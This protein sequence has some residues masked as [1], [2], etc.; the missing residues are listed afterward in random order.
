M[1]QR[2]WVWGSIGL[3]LGASAPISSAQ[4]QGREVEEEDEVADLLGDAESIEELAL[5]DLLT[6]ETDVAA[7]VSSEVREAPS[8]ITVI[9]HEEIVRMGARDLIDV[10]RTVPGLYFG[11]D[12]EGAVGLGF[13]G[14]WGHE[15]KILLIIDGQEVNE[16]LYSTTQFGNHYPVDHIERIEVVRGPGSVNYGGY[17]ELAV[18]RITTRGAR[19]L[20]GFA[21]SLT[22]GQLWSTSLD[23]YGRRNLS[24]QYGAES[25][26]IEGLAVSLAGFV[27][28]GRRGRAQYTDFYGTSRPIYLNRHDPLFV[29]LGVNYRQLSTRVIVDYYR[30]PM[31]DAFDAVLVERPNMSFL[32]VLAGTKLTIPATDDLTITPG[33]NF[34]Y[35]APWQMTELEGGGVDYV[36]IG[37]FY[38]REVMRFRGQVVA[39][40]EAHEYVTATLGLQAYA[41]Q[42]P[43]LEEPDPQPSVSYG[44]IAGFVEVSSMNPV[45]N[46]TAGLR[47]ETHS[48][49]GPSIVPRFGLT[50]VFGDFHLKGLFAM[51]FRAPG[52]ENISLNPDIVPERTY[53]FELEAGYRISEEMSLTVNAYDLTIRR[54][55]IYNYDEVT[56]EESYLNYDRVG[57]RGIDAEYRLRQDWGYAALT[58]AYYQVGSLLSDREDVPEPYE[59]P[60]SARA[61]LGAPR[62]QVSLNA[63]VTPIPGLSIGP[64]AVVTSGRWGY[65]SAD[66]EGEPVL[67]K[68]DT[69]VLLNLWARYAFDAVAPGVY[70][71]AGVFNLLDAD[72]LFVQPYNG[73]RPPI[74]GT[75]REVLVQVGYA[76]PLD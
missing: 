29:N 67:D 42:V 53:A 52:I 43:E 50:R 6:M 7:S 70:V 55:I 5:E 38:A 49:Y 2:G 10:L 46:A 31:I 75:G 74:P 41:D 62:H 19:E 11:S 24:L 60:Q 63:A 33:L 21:G 36:D 25:Q 56:D 8:I 51:A 45:V 4:G 58:Y 61:L 72:E 37:L 73:Y 69:T 16:L 22:Y 65:L 9:T 13:R 3:V 71:G 68:T 1:R 47:V 39:T 76:Q 35:Q 18:I 12:V 48:K 54:P 59:V 17:A 20:D 23:R 66:D 15:G 26:S 27:G 64:S 34:T 14:H 28:Q 57:T 40:W 32:S 30:T 44:N